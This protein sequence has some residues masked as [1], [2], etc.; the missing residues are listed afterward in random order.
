MQDFD[1]CL[2]LCPGEDPSGW[3]RPCA[4]IEAYARAARACGLTDAELQDDILAFWPLA[5]MQVEVT[6]GFDRMLCIYLLAQP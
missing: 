4:E 1:V 5:G 2:F 3:A 6:T